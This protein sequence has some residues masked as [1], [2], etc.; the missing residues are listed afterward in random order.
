MQNNLIT[1]FTSRIYWS[2]RGHTLQY[3]QTAYSNGIQH[4]Y[5]FA[6]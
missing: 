5:V 6:H 2:S 4:N 1:G 3:F